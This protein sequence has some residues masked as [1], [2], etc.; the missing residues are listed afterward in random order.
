M[1]CF[2][3]LAAERVSDIGGNKRANKHLSLR[4]FSAQNKLT[5]NHLPVSL[6]EE[7]N[8]RAAKGL[9]VFLLEAEQTDK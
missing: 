9:F 1:Y 6:V 8:K 4:L 3:T 5:N 2:P 7:R